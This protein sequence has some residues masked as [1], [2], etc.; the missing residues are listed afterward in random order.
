[1]ATS[2]VKPARVSQPI[3]SIQPLVS[4]T[5]TRRTLGS[6]A[7]IAERASNMLL[8]VTFRARA[9]S[10]GTTQL[11]A[12]GT[13][14]SNAT[15]GAVWSDHVTNG[16]TFWQSVYGSPTNNGLTCPV[17]FNEFAMYFDC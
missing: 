17:S 4:A 12:A 1:M 10:A 15:W 6:I 2:K 13:S 8:D 7:T 5:I 16:A 11:G 9:N 14:G 3:V